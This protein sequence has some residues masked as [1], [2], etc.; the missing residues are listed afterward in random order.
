MRLTCP[1]CG[2]QYEVP[3]E[4]IPTEGRD[5][6]CSNCGDTWYQNHPDHVTEAAPDP[7]ESEV[8]AESADITE[9][10][11]EPAMPDDEPAPEYEP[12]ID[13]ETVVENPSRNLDSAVSDI[14]REEAEREQQLRADE[15]DNLETQPE[16]G[17]DTHTDNEAGRRAR[18]AQDRMAR[19]RGEEPGP[20]Q[21]GAETGT[22]R[23]LLPDIEEINSTLRNSADKGNAAGGDEA[24]PAQPPRKQGG[25]RRGFLVMILFGVILALLYVNAPKISAA[26]PQADP[27]IGAYVALVDQAR[28]WLDNRANAVLPIQ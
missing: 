6:Q 26:I 25:F 20:S 5:V 13:H 27:M 8:A 7:V 22:R 11:P 16:L 24:L 28:L 9:T 1:N 4:V 3:S 23:G 21:I 18:E 19:M 15:N 12:A 17:L 2:A 10:A 14:L